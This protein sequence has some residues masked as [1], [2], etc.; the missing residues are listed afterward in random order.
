[1]SQYW[2]T[3]QSSQFVDRITSLQNIPIFE[4]SGG[5]FDN[6]PPTASAQADEASIAFRNCNA[7][8]L[9]HPFTA[10]ANQGKRGSI[11]LVRVGPTLVAS[12]GWT[13]RRR[14]G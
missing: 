14:S 8:P 3:L 13:L 6:P 10:G 2:F 7:M 5:V 1:V 12:A 11:N 9:T 4:T